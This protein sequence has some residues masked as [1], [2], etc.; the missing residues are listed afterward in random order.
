M[1]TLLPWFIADVQG[2][3]SASQSAVA[4][5]RPIVPPCCECYNCCHRCASR[6]CKIRQLRDHAHTRISRT[7]CYYHRRHP[8]AAFFTTEPPQKGV[9]RLASPAKAA[10]CSTPNRGAASEQQAEARALAQRIRSELPALKEA[11][12]KMCALDYF[13]SR[14][15]TLRSKICLPLLWLQVDNVPD[16][17]LHSPPPRILP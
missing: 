4:G 6:D 1:K 2:V 3:D 17:I 11:E 5:S 10:L 14:V 12:V 16:G 8:A 9:G 15:R 7:D 13:Y